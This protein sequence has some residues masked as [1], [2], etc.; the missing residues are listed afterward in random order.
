MCYGGGGMEPHYSPAFDEF[1]D[2][3]CDGDGGVM[4]SAQALPGLS[5]SLLYGLY[6]AL[7]DWYYTQWSSPPPPPH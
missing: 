1:T 7:T 4:R 5:L 3:E 6:S 2:M